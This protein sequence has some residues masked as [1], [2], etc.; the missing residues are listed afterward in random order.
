MNS[1]RTQSAIKIGQLAV[2]TSTITR[3]CVVIVFN[4]IVTNEL[5]VSKRILPTVYTKIRLSVYIHSSDFFVEWNY[6]EQYNV[7]F[8][9]NLKFL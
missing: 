4:R 8:K 3:K 5:R 2:V 9:C 7:S 1:S 6:T